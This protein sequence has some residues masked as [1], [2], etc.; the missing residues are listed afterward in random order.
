MSCFRG[1]GKKT[2]FEVFRRNASFVSGEGE[3]AD[4]GKEGGLFSF[5][6]LVCCIY[7]YKHLAAFQPFS[8]PKLL[9][10]SFSVD[11]NHQKHL[12]FISEIREKQWERVTTEVDIMPN[13]EA[14]K[15][16]YMRCCWV[17]DYWAQA[18]KNI[19]ILGELCEHGWQIRNNMLDFVW[20]TELNFRKVEKTVAW[21]TKGC[22]CQTGCQTNRCKCRK[23]DAGGGY[24]GPGCKCVNCLNV[25]G[26]KEDSTLNISNDILDTMDE[27][28]DL[29]YLDE[30]LELEYVGAQETVGEEDDEY[31]SFGSFDHD[32]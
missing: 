12:K 2:F 24:C 16:H 27:A 26:K 18:D 14:L 6:R 30:T 9:L 19:M 29:E 17:F 28:E 8:T 11:S 31:W 4:A 7:F 15:L 23:N 20:D 25:P 21:Y 13:A 5:Y 10:E 22:G 3:F 32:I 1:F